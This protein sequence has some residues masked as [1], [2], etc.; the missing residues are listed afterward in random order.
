MSCCGSIEYMAPEVRESTG[1]NY[2]VDFYTLGAFLYEMV[3]GVPPYYNDQPLF[4]NEE[5]S[6]SYK[7]LVKGLIE[8]DVG[9]RIN[10]FKMIKTSK[11]LQDISWSGVKK[12]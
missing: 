6:S 4:F 12:C 9:E 7:T 3:M 2:S 5:N 11:W 1:Y 10:S 8:E